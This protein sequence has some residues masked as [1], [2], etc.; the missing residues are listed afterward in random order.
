MQLQTEYIEQCTKSARIELFKVSDY[1]LGSVKVED[2]TIMTIRATVGGLQELTKTPAG[3]FFLVSPQITVTVESPDKMKQEAMKKPVATPSNISDILSDLTN[4]QVV[5]II[6]KQPSHETVEERG[7][8][9]RQ[10]KITIEIDPFVASRNFEFRDEK[11]N[12]LYYVRWN[13]RVSTA[14]VD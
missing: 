12:P 1:K 11:G 8:D 7:S 3:V 10:Y 14:F 9:G 5:K 2:G 4:W 13:D 6:E